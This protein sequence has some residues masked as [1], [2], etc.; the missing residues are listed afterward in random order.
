MAWV[1]VL[2]LG[3][4]AGVLTTV[5][6]L[7][8]GML[9]V[10]VLALTLDPITALSATAMGL[11]VGNG[12]RVWMYRRELVW[13]VA[14]PMALGAIPGAFL[15]G[16]LVAWMPPWVVFGAMLVMSTLAVVR[17]FGRSQAVA[18]A[19]GDAPVGALTGAVTATSGGGGL[20]VSPWLLARGLVGSAYV[21]TV[22]VVAVSL[23]A[24]RIAA[25]GWAGATDLDT[26]GLGVLLAICLPLGNLLGH[27]LR[28]RLSLRVQS[29][30][31]VGVILTA[32][33]LATG[34]LVR[35]LVQEP[36]LARMPHEAS[37]TAGASGAPS[38]GLQPAP[39]SAG[40]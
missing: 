1:L 40:D 22:A 7:G 33:A 8:G 10:A 19:W 32:L 31:Q 35:D 14:I 15:A 21:G 12:H 34:G 24:S 25:Y 27:Q 11:L 13:R 16:L 26:V 17:V 30:V 2:V 3:L 4:L 9:L 6:G 28:R 29:R 5:A 38:P 18:P 36:A 39:R 37:V 23:H 20:I